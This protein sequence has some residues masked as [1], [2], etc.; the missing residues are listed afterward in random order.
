MLSTYMVSSYHY[1]MY[2]W[3]TIQRLW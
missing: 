2:I 3:R 1:Y